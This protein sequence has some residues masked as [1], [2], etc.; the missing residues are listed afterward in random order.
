VIGAPSIV[1]QVGQGI[2]YCHPGSILPPRRELPVRPVPRSPKR[3]GEGSRVSSLYPT[4]LSTINQKRDIHHERIYLLSKRSETI[5]GG[6][7]VQSVG[8][9][10]KHH[11]RRV[12]PTPVGKVV[13][14]TSRTQGAD[15]LVAR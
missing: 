11:E 14:F 13:L 3:D 12:A 15:R 1:P 9:G 7:A 4:S 5:R 2:N 8:T 10:K 6:Y